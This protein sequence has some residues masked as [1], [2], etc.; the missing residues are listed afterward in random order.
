MK[1]IQL[2][3]EMTERELTVI[4][5]ALQKEFK[6]FGFRLNLTKHFMDYALHSDAPERATVAA[7]DVYKT[8]VEFLKKKGHRFDEYK[9]MKKRFTVAVT[10]ERTNMTVNLVFDFH[11]PPRDTNI[12]YDVALQSIIRKKG[13]R[14]DNNPVDLWVRVHV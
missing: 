8:L 11:K 7:A 2:L 13:F 14:M 1:I 4:S 5:V 12:P 10:N 6:K 9:N 3:I